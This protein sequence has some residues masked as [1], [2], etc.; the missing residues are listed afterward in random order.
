MLPAV[1]ESN[2][3]L[4]RHPVFSR[5]SDP[6]LPVTSSG[7]YLTLPPL[8]FSDSSGADDEVVTEGSGAM[9]AYREML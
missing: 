1:W 8:I 6:M 9:H 7:P 4:H 2:S 5:I 3:G